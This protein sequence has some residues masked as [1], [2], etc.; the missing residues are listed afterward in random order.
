M[1]NAGTSNVLFTTPHVHGD[2]AEG[3]AS[4]QKRN[5]AALRLGAGKMKG[6][7]GNVWNTGNSEE[8]IK[9]KRN[10]N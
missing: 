5:Q 1:R 6:V 10:I 9:K 2:G 4:A 8:R 7:T 3:P